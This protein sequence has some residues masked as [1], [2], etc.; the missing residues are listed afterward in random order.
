VKLSTFDNSFD[1][2]ERTSHA[3]ALAAG[4]LLNV[5]LKTSYEVS[6]AEPLK[7]AFKE[8]GYSKDSV[9]GS[10]EEFQKFRSQVIA[11]NLPKTHATLE[12]LYR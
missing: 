11:K 1:S 6:L 12:M 8:G 7:A 3:M 5:P 10:I 4:F 2:F 9:T